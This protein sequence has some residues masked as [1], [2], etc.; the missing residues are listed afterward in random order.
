MNEPAPR[1]DGSSPT[2]PPGEGREPAPTGSRP[3][4]W[5]LLLLAASLPARAETLD[6]FAD[7]GQWQVIASDGLEAHLSAADG[8]MRLDYDFR[9]HAGYVVLRKKLALELPA[10]WAFDLRLKGEGPRNNFEFKL[11]DPS[12]D[13]VWW[14]NRRLYQLPADFKDLRTR[15]SRFEFAW[16]PLG[17][18]QPTSWRRSS[19]RSRRGRAARARSSST[20]STSSVCRRSRPSRP[21]PWCTPAARPRLCGGQGARWRCGHRLAGCRRGLRNPDHRPRR[22]ARAGRPPDPLAGGLGPALVPGLRRG[23]R[24]AHAAAP[25]IQIHGGGTDAFIAPDLELRYLLLDFSYMQG[26]ELR[27]IELLPASLGEDR[28]GLIARLAALGRRGDYPR[29]FGGER[30]GGETSF[31]TV[32][33]DDGGRDEALINEDGAVEPWRGAFSLEPFVKVDERLLGWAEAQSRPRLARGGLPVPAVALEF[34][35][36]VKLDVATA[37]S[38]AGLYL[39]YRLKNGDSKH[40]LVGLVMTLRPFQVDPPWQFLSQQGGVTQVQKLEVTR[41]GAALAGRPVLRFEPAAD[42]ANGQAFAEGSLIGRL[43]AWQLPGTPV[44][45]DRDDRQASAYFVWLYPMQPGESREVN[46]VLPWPG[47]AMPNGPVAFA[48]H[49]QASLAYWEE[50]LGAVDLQLPPAAG[51][52]A[53]T[54]KSALGHILIHRDGAGI[55]PGS[56]SYE[57]S[58]IRDGA[59]TSSALLRFGLY[60][61]ARDFLRWFAPY[62][63]DNGKRPAAST[64]AAPTR[65]RRTTAMAS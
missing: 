65:C 44:V 19:W 53:A 23:R 46:A 36:G 13:N 31:W 7:P 2:R 32:A 63:F 14:V 26:L 39:R 21:S 27:E 17:G 54:V 11:L 1:H 60:D 52:L 24:P 9:G 18:G 35:E 59:L 43:R 5:G 51:D 41:E 45:D 58:W 64:A 8:V 55:Q 56:R 49:L 28:N 30:Q 15:G 40:H 20:G 47:L 62:Q 22:A 10:R 57:R 25:R 29:A 6:D 12:L 38:P 37:A 50:R 16:G 48:P 4:P 34:P 3:S 61:A 42:G 33:G